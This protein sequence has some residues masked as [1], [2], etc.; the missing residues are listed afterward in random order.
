MGRGVKKIAFITTVDHN[1]GDDFVRE[2]IKYLLKS[3]NPNIDFQFQNIHKHSP[4]TARYGFEQ[5]RNLRLSRRVDK[6]ISKSLTKDRI[7]EADIIV[8]SGAPVY[9]C[10]EKGGTHC[11]KVEWYE[12]LIKDRLSKNKNAILLN[13]AAG[14]CQKY[15]SFG[16]E[17]CDKCNSYMKEFYELAQSKLKREKS[18]LMQSLWISRE[19][20]KNNIDQRVANTISE[21]FNY[22]YAISEERLNE[23]TLDVF[24][25]FAINNPI[26]KGENKIK[27]VQWVSN[28]RDGIITQSN[29]LKVAKHHISILN[30]ARKQA[31]DNFGFEIR[32]K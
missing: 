4:I 25:Y 7:L 14:T 8:Q 15:H 9:W 1:V 22:I 28:S 12:P 31:I 16:D 21:Y 5:F 3:A 27:L 6:I 29:S 19:K 26:E 10:H 17:F 11:Y 23:Q 30:E 24:N 13:F 18:M 32:L 2:G 20:D